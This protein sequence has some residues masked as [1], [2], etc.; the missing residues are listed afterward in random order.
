MW[1]YKLY[2]DDPEIVALARKR[3]TEHLNPVSEK[4]SSIKSEPKLTLVK[5]PNFPEITL[6]EQKLLHLAI[7][8]TEMVVV[9]TSEKTVTRTASPWAIKMVLGPVPFSSVDPNADADDDIESVD[10]EFEEV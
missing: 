6:E 7:L 9:E 4:W 3:L 1:R 8:E 10:F 5:N 2:R